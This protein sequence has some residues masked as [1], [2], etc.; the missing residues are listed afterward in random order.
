M[1]VTGGSSSSWSLWR[2]WRTLRQYTV[3]VPRNSI[4]VIHDGFSNL[5]VCQPPDIL[6][7]TVSVCAMQLCEVT[8]VN[9]NW[10]MTCLRCYE[11]L[12]RSYHCATWGHSL[13]M[14]TGSW[15]CDAACIHTHTPLSQ[16]SA[17]L[18]HL[19]AHITQGHSQRGRGRRAIPPIVDW[20]D[21]LTGKTGFV[22]T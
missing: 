1:Y 14:L 6:L 12:S 9:V 18:L 3:D 20:V 2:H 15:T 7:R 8:L 13:A 22:G 16:S 10:V 19:V 17:L 4:T 21:F 11:W 5:V